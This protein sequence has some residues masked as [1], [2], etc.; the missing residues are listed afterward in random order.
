M[1]TIN[2]LS[3]FPTDRRRERTRAEIRGCGA[4]HTVYSIM[5]V[6]DS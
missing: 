1:V 4:E 3:R 5:G 2:M 6:G